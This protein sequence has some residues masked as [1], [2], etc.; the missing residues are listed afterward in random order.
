MLAAITHADGHVTVN[1]TPKA[2]GVG[3]VYFVNQ[4]LNN[5]KEGDNV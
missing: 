1:K 3:Q 2:T 4:F 5:S